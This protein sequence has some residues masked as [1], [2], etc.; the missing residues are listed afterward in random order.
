[1]NKN[2]SEGLAPPVGCRDAMRCTRL[3]Q[4]GTRVFLLAE[5]PWLWNLHHVHACFR[6]KLIQPAIL[7]ML[8]R[9]SGSRVRALTVTF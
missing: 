8:H 4:R 5:L 3:T 6:Y 7:A 2:T 1:M 9:V